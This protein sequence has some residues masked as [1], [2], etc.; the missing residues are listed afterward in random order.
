MQCVPC[1]ESQ[2]T[3]GVVGAAWALDEDQGAGD[4]GMTCGFACDEREELVRA[5]SRLAPRIVEAVLEKSESGKLSEN[6]VIPSKTKVI[7]RRVC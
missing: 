2:D 4:M 7:V 5:P 6:P 3:A 1:R